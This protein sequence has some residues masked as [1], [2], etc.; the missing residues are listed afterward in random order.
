MLSK[1]LFNNP[2]LTPE[3]LAGV[4]PQDAG[5]P[6]ECPACRHPEYE[7][8]L[9]RRLF[10]CPRCGHY[11]KIG[12]R[13]RALLTLDPDSFEE[14]GAL[15]VSS[16]PLGFPGY[17]AK[18]AASRATSGESEAVL[19]GL[20]RL[21]GQPCA[22]F[23]M[24]PGF[25][26][27]SMG[28]ATGE[29]ITRLFELALARRLPVVGYAVSGGAR[30]QEGILSLMQMAKVSGAVRAH[31]DAG[32]F[33]VIV[34]CDATTGGVAASFAMQA[35]VILAEPGALIGFAGPRVIEQTTRQ[36]LPDGFQ[37]A[38]FQLRQ[39]FVG[40]IS[41]RGEQRPLLSLLVK[42]HSEA[43]DGRV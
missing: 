35:D 10:A 22:F 41:P 12:A 31:S 18:L 38:E 36:K 21:M 13:Q 9:R 16:D 29:K 2:G 33:Y 37:K 32:L 43:S 30:V 34:L 19:T 5:T 24:E 7:E 15:V 27:G 20:G 28:A 39:G 4:S 8:E 11:M 1:T 14:T 17:A 3:R 6:L 42:M 25:M 23:A 40:R 26:M